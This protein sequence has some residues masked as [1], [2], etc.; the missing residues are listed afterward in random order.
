MEVSGDSQSQPASSPPAPLSFA[1]VV[2]GAGILQSSVGGGSQA[3]SF[4]GGAGNVAAV[5]GGAAPNSGVFDLMVSL[6]DP[7]VSLREPT[8]EFCTLSQ[9]DVQFSEGERELSSD[10]RALL[11]SLLESHTASGRCQHSSFSQSSSSGN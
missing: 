2:G 4:S 1:A 8:S 11:D 5:A 10:D 9:N 3:P 7:M 6:R